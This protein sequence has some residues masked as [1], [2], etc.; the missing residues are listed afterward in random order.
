MNI[1]II[2]DDFI[3]KGDVKRT[4]M[5][6]FPDFNVYE[7]SSTK[8]ALVIME[9]DH[10]D[11]ILTDIIMPGMDGMTFIES[12][13]NRFLDTQWIVMTGLSGHIY[14]RKAMQLGVRDYLLK[15]FSKSELSETINKLIN[16]SE[17]SS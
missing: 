10:M 11:I 16:S 9:E 12:Y 4:L 5:K 7:A 8:E 6:S 1:L 13:R 3:I 2:D 17:S 15:P 14:F